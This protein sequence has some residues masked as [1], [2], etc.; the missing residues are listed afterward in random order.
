[1]GFPTPPKKP[2]VVLLALGLIS[3]TA[4]AEP[5]PTRQ[6]VGEDCTPAALTAALM[7]MH[8]P[9]PPAVRAASVRRVAICAGQRA[10]GALSAALVQD[11]DPVVK[12]EVARGLLRIGSV[13]VL[14]QAA[15]DK[16][17]PE[18]VRSVAQRTLQ[19]SEKPKP[20]V[21]QPR[22]SA[23]DTRVASPD[24]P[25]AAPAKT[26]PPSRLDLVLAAR[27]PAS[28]AAEAKTTKTSN[29]AQPKPAPA[30]VAPAV[31]APAPVAPAP[32]APVVVAPAIG[33]RSA[34]AVVEKKS[35][36]VVV[37][38]KPAPFI[39]R[40]PE[41]A[42]ARA[43]TR[44]PAAPSLAPNLAPSLAPIL[45]PAPPAPEEPKEPEGPPDGTALA[46]TASTLAGGLWG[47]SMSLLAQ[48]DSP[49]VVALVGGAGAIIGGGT[50][51]GITRFGLRPTPGQAFWYTNAT[52]WGTLAGLAAWSASGSQSPKLKYGLLMGGESVGIGLGIWGARQWEWTPGQILLANSFLV[53]AGL[54]GMG[55]KLALSGEL[56]GPLSPLVGYG[57]APAM[58]G[59]TVAAR[60]LPVTNNDLGLMAT[61]S[62]WGG[63]TGGLIGSGLAGTG[64]L[65]GSAGQGGALLGL[66]VGYLG[67]GALSPFVEVRPRLLLV[68]S[69]GLLAG[70]VLGLGTAM[71]IEPNGSHWALGAGLGGLGYM[72]G[73][74]ALAPHLRLGEQASNMTE[75][76]AVYGAGAWYLATRAAG[77]VPQNRVIGGALAGAVAAGTVGLVAS[78]YANPDSVD[79]ATA[80]ASSLAGL[81]I[82]LGS[83][84]LLTGEKGTADLVG[85]LVGAAGGFVGGATF[86][87]THRLR[88][89]DVYGA[90]VGSG[91][92]LVVGLLAPTLASESWQDSRRTAGG[93]WLGL[94]LGAVGGTALAAWQEANSRQVT[95]ALVSGVLGTSLGAGAGMLAPDATS[96]PTRVGAVAGSTLGIAAGLWLDHQLHLSDGLGDNWTGLAGLGL[97]LGALDGILAADVARSEDS[98]IRARQT[99]GGVLAGT[100]AGLAGALVLSKLVRPSGPDYF[101][102]AGADLL[103]L[104]LGNG[105]ALMSFDENRDNWAPSLRLAGSL[106]GMAGGAWAA[107]SLRL[108]WVDMGAGTYGAGFGA[109]LGTF[110]ASLHR[111]DWPGDRMDGAGAS[112]G[113][114]LGGAGAA[115][116]AHATDA[117]SRQVN[118]M[119]ASA[120]LGMSA[121]LGLGMALPVDYSQPE[122]IGFVAGGAGLFGAGLLLE[123][124]LHLSTGEGLHNPRFM[125]AMGAL[126]GAAEGYWLAHAL[127]PSGVDAERRF[128]GLLFGTSVG[129]ASGFLLSRFVR[130][131]P[132]EVGLTLGAG[133][134]GSGLGLGVAMLAVD[135][136]GRA[137][138]L[139]TMVGSLGMMAAASWAAHTDRLRV[140]PLALT[141]GLGYGALL[142]ALAPTLG[143][144]D[145]PGWQ[146]HVTGGLLA[147]GAGAGLAANLLAQATHA[148][149]EQSQLVSAATGLGVTAG[150]GL[151]MALPHDSNQPERV[152]VVAGG[153]G[154]FGASL[155]LENRL[156]LSTGEDLVDP[157][158]L[159]SLGAITGAT[160]GVLMAAAMDPSGHVGGTAGLQLTGGAF[161]GASV[162]A[163]SG[164]LLSRWVR[165]DGEQLSLTMGS[166]VLGGAL[167]LGVSMLAREQAGRPD[168]LAA[169]GG[170]LGAMGLSAWAAHED[171]LQTD[172]WA[173]SLGMMYGGLVGSI[174]P[175]VMDRDWPGWTRRTSGGLL[176]GAA[177]VGLGSSLL[178]TATE[179]DG[180]QMTLVTMAT[181]LG[182]GTGL[183][184]GMAWPDDSSRPERIGVV[185]GSVGFFGTS[186]LLEKTLHLS[187]GEGLSSPVLLSF[188]GLMAGAA[189]GVVMAGALDPSGLVENTPKLR[190]W[191][192]A[193]FGAS[194]GASTGFLLSRF[195]DPRPGDVGRVLVGGLLGGTLGL[196]TSMLVEPTAGRSDSLA[197]IGGSLGVMA[198]LST[199]AHSTELQLNP[200]LLLTGL[201]Y[202]GFLGALAPSLMDATWDWNRRTK[203]GALA[204]SAGAGLT[205]VVLA[206]LVDV[207]ASTAGLATLA[208]IN[209]AVAGL[210]YGLLADPQN[211]QGARIG[212]AAGAVAG[213]AV[214]GTLWPR[215]HPDDNA[216]SFTLSMMGLGAWNGLFLP[217]LGHADSGSVSEHRLWGG[218]LAGGA[219]ASLASTALMPFVH[220]SPDLMA[221]ALTLDAML[222]GS[223]AGVSMLV[224]DRFDAPVAGL[225][226]GGLAGL[227]LGGALHDQIDIHEEDTPLMM[228]GPFEGV[229]LGASLPFVLRQPDDV[230][231]AKVGAGVVAGGL[232]GGATAVLLSRWAKPTRAEATMMGATSLIGTALA[233][234]SVLMAD[235]LHDQ[236]GAGIVMG[237]TALGL[238]AGAGLAPR[239]V[240]GSD[241]VPY[242]MGG[243]FLGG[244]E[245]LVFAWAGRASST[246]DYVG[247]GLVGA[248][249]G[250]T[251]GLARSLREEEQ[252]SRTM[253]AGGFAAWGLWVGAFGGALLNRDPHEVTAGGLLGANVGMGVGY[254]L[255][256]A[257]F[258]EPRDFGWLSLFGAAGTV[259]GGGAGAVL[260]SRS[261]PRPVLAGLTIGP[262]VGITAGAI[263]LP[264]LRQV[265]REASH[266]VSSLN[267]WQKVA[268]FFHSDDSAAAPKYTYSSDILEARGKPGLLS[269]A[270]H[271]LGQAVEITSW[272][273]M[274][275]ALP[276]A[277]GTTDGSTPLFIGVSG[278][279]K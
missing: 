174:A 230:S 275:G 113:V 215:L 49:G 177:G 239:L 82:G 267:V 140:D 134:L 202:G 37:G 122:R 108:R 120:A 52:A 32:V 229:A 129:A 180:A 216:G 252:V 167:G 182:L 192:G 92:G 133:V 117:D 206:N 83:A 238:A 118:L 270:A 256:A 81:S 53:G 18:A 277:P 46:V 263:A 253:A 8:P 125:S 55:G 10:S 60:Y 203:G 159:S 155:L 157:G 3:P 121:G 191:G 248:S 86:A 68:G 33:T 189:E 208:G 104:S 71:M 61:S 35:P 30:L 269:R 103:G 132:S 152:G 222:G 43:E 259:L 26:T 150:L 15:A 34:P 211:S 141:A 42:V 41:R 111:R 23:P 27:E 24:T 97:G 45:P 190:K 209:G 231:A 51:W 148:T 247:G 1:M 210:G 128:G 142:G 131:E 28:R 69:G 93:A 137:D 221:N 246:N 67:A 96:R 87:H 181:T 241:T 50:A 228:L 47:G 151:G 240:L 124:Q 219:T 25:A 14:R 205:A 188:S 138:S 164:F 119:A 199:A 265:T 107:H 75:L 254:G 234:G 76:G 258:F 163:A 85:S 168:S 57:M 194:L 21:A 218:V 80:V 102:V 173:L 62:L 262:A 260:S 200:P 175:T 31:A 72:A 183:G 179:A 273:P 224:S 171:R 95:L 213:L 257:H 201:A 274:I 6:S 207:D 272:S 39:A 106:M 16:S 212:L 11:P 63:W 178:A 20:I 77:D 89:P 185:A 136:E 160:E 169:L 242:M 135:H 127:D 214:G 162:G 105:I 149:T 64:L 74:L 36:P 153:L 78:G 29:P 268:G 145:W 236:R 176:A 245:G 144:R 170:S 251:L 143:E 70:N 123:H 40:E 233:G 56:G 217:M 114:A 232:A 84:K 7:D 48:Q 88:P 100:S 158:L 65:A 250:A 90:A 197:M 2:L 279:W 223:A 9:A 261:D 161:F 112:L 226:G 109:L 243:A 156:H 99:Q 5:S 255:L 195:V 19:E 227:V 17:Q 276:A 187:T 101:A 79:H 204:G 184:L 66:G 154:F 126:T 244:V 54:A 44:T 98:G 116:L 73:T 4:L 13:E 94:G 196:G 59:A 91:Y 220:V 198:A 237:G 58:V 115:A 249:L 172:G 12:A 110:A 139:A 186:L 130:P 147:G 165:P 193:I 266:A 22:A 264:R 225:L 278:F 166:G 146:R 38:E 271:H 235:E